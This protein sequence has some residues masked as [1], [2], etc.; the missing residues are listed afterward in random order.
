MKYNSISKQWT[1]IF[2]YDKDF[3]SKRHTATID[4]KSEMIYICTE[5][6]KLLTINLKANA[7]NTISDTPP[8]GGYSAIIFL[9][10]KMYVVNGFKHFV[11]DESIQGSFLE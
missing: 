11:F 7:I 6:E 4:N 2:D 3:I 8:F 1:K 9:D 5:Q 10:G